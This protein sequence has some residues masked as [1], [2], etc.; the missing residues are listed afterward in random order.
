MIR[1]AGLCLI[2]LLFAIDAK[3][4]DAV[5]THT[6]FYKY[7]GN[8]AKPYIEISW[9]INPTSLRFQAD[10]NGKVLAKIKTDIIITNS[11]NPLS[12]QFV[13][14]TPPVDDISLARNQSIRDT[15]KYDITPG[16]YTISFRLTELGDTN[17]I[18]T[19]TSEVSIDTPL[20]K[21]AYYSGISLLDTFYSSSASSRFLRNGQYQL[22]LSINFLDDNRANIHYHVELYNTNSIHNDQY[23]LIQH[24]YISKKMQEGEIYKLKRTDTIQTAQ[25]LPYTG[26]FNIASLPSGNYYL[27]ATLMNARQEPVAVRSLFFQ[28]S[29]KNPVRIGDSTT[30]ATDSMQAVNILDLNNTFVGKYNIPQLMA[31]VKMIW[32]IASPVEQNS[33]KSFLKKPDLIYMQYFVYNFWTAKD[34]NNPKKAWEQYA[35]RVR[36]TNKLFGK[37]GYETERGQIYLKYGKPTERIIVT[38]E[39]GSLPYEI[40]QYNVTE[41]MSNGVFLFYRPANMLN[42]MQLLHSN[43]PGE[44]RNTNW[45]NFL[46][47][48][49][50]NSDHSNAR[51][52]QYFYRR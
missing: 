34:K 27:N 12:D 9:E 50:S 43:I 18:F 10:E 16:T 13:L 14:Q 19:Y 20:E 6:H 4:I 49:N 22:P 23:P 39:P 37:A 11:S 32:P 28:R 40:W 33:I 8:K 46:Y 35:D 38:N 51:A 47:L 2:S 5:V 1:W 44:V 29:N 30:S 26:T 52:E 41:K 42:D 31:I 17:N 48:P 7:D 45:R 25:L 3:A 21:T 36:E 24:I 15:R